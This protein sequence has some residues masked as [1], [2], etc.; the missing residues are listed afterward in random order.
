MQSCTRASDAQAHIAARSAFHCGVF[1]VAQYAGSFSRAQWL[2]AH[3]GGAA[4]CTTAR[5]GT[6]EICGPSRAGTGRYELT[7]AKGIGLM[8][9]ASSQDL[10]ALESL[11]SRMRRWQDMVCG[12]GYAGACTPVE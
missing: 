6:V 8:F 2:N 7:Y 3:Y 9:Y 5:G 10:S 11:Q 4:H 1:H 12:V